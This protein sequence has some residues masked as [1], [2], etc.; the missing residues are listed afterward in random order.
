MTTETTQRTV[1]IPF[2]GFYESIHTD[3]IDRTEETMFSDGHGDFDSTAAHEFYIACDYRKVFHR[4]AQAYAEDFATYIEMPSLKFIELD[5]PR[6]YNFRTDKIICEISE[7]DVLKMFD[8]TPREA[9][10]TCATE[11]HTS[12]SG[13]DSFYDPDI[14]TWGDPLEWDHVQLTTLMQAYVEGTH[15]WA[16]YDQNYSE[17]NIIEDWSGDGIIENWLCDAV[18][19]AELRGIFDR[20]YERRD[21]A[22]EMTA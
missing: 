11:R 21:A 3:N 5:S 22:E 9:L 4:Y 15:S 17:M 7:V 16:R 20:M 10:V 6:E 19:A 12:R 14:S 13:F 18:D 2:T 1:S 8:N